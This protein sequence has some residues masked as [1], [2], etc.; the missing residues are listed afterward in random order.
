MGASSSDDRLLCEAA[1]CLAQRL[2]STSTQVLAWK[3]HPSSQP[4]PV[5]S[6]VLVRDGQAVYLFSAAHVLA[7]FKHQ[8]L[9]TVS[10]GDLVRLPDPYRLRLT[11]TEDMGDHQHDQMDAAVLLPDSVP[12]DLRKR[13][14]ELNEIQPRSA[15]EGA[16]YLL[17][18]HPANKTEVDRWKQETRSE[19]KPLISREVPAEDYVKLG[20]DP[21]TH[22]V[23]GWQNKWRTST[24]CHD[25]RNLEGSSGGGIWCFDPD[26]KSP[27]QLVA[28]LTALVPHSGRK[29]MVGTRIRVHC[30]LRRA[31]VGQSS[32]G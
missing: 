29:V 6:G 27:P 21:R 19:R 7:E 25:A 22:L 2:W 28:T 9:W 4:R 8:P 5:G 23:L 13:A 18:G 17:L 15:P 26:S 24:G 10:D 16:R 14:L 11:G 20:Y 1:D 31:L 3:E 12:P 32:I 30:D